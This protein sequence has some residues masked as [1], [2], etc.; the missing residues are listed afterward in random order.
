MKFFSVV[1]VLLFVSVGTFADENKIVYLATTTSTDNSGLMNYLLPE[2]QKDTGYEY[3]VIAVGTGKALQMGRA[4]DVD[5]LLVHAKVAELEFVEDGYGIN[6]KE[7]MYNDFIIVGPENDPG[8]AREAASVSDALQQ[9]ASSGSL[10]VSRG[11]DSGT[12]KKELKLWESVGIQPNGRW[13]REV[14][15]GMGKTL[16]IAGELDAYTMTDRGTWI[17]SE[18]RSP[19]RLVVEDDPILFNQYGAIAVNPELHNVNYEGAI[20][21]IQWLI[22]EKGQFLINDYKIN[23]K[24][25]FIANAD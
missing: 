22:S 24:N 19:L 21:L 14:G 2:L 12:H 8:N 23:G 25:L 5:V 6:R 4:G 16:Q 15:Q 9:I 11:D 13:Y 10:F 1:L 20:A 7:I 17:F 18:K 3:R